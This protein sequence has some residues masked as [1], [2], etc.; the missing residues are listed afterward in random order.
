MS[1]DDKNSLIMLLHSE[2]MSD[3]LRSSPSLRKSIFWEHLNFWHFLVYVQEKTVCTIKLLSPYL[4]TQSHHSFFL[5]N[6]FTHKHLNFLLLMYLFN[7]VKHSTFMVRRFTKLKSSFR[8]Q[9][10]RRRIPNLKTSVFSRDWSGTMW[11][12]VPLTAFLIWESWW[13]KSFAKAKSPTIVSQ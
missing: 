13:S 8:R 4:L 2:T 10:S 9:G 1:E 5:S 3:L 12:T 11:P 6:F 7:P